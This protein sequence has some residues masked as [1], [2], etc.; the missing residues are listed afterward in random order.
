MKTLQHNRH[1]KSTFPGKRKGFTLIELLASVAIIG[2]LAAL[3]LPAYEQ[4]SDRARFSE[5]ILAT[6]IYRNA[7]EVAIFRNNIT[8][9][10]QLTS[11]SFGIPPIQLG[12]VGGSGGVGPLIGMFNGQIIVL[13]PDDGT[14]LAGLTYILETTDLE[15]PIEWTDGGSCRVGGYC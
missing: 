10:N 13:W 3:A 8:T 15:P 1:A 7:A 5:A 6:S 4:Y 2:F 14:S 11:G 12:A 9:P